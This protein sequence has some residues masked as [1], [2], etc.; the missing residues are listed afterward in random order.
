MGN[1]L[2]NALRFMRQWTGMDDPR[3]VAQLFASG[4]PTTFTEFVAAAMDR[5]AELAAGPHEPTPSMWMMYDGDDPE[6]RRAWMMRE[7]TDA[8]AEE[9]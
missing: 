5:G 6:W 1:N 3:D 2:C 8:A 9:G 4:D 7:H